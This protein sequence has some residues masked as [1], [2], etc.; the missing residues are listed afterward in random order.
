MNSPRRYCTPPSWVAMLLM[1]LGMF[2][3]L[4]DELGR[5]ARG[6]TTMSCHTQLPHSRDLT[7]GRSTIREVG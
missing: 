5:A 1:Y 3:G 7:D 2:A 4:S 6:A